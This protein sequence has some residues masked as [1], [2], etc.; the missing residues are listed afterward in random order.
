MAVTGKSTM[1]ARNVGLVQT[2]P[3]GLRQVFSD[4]FDTHVAPDD[5]VG[6]G[7]PGTS[8]FGGD[9][10]SVSKPTSVLESG[11]EALVSQR[12]GLRLQHEIVLEH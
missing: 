10:A 9:S 6:A 7:R 5:G 11:N 3:R 1:F 4:E 2:Y 8:A 12:T